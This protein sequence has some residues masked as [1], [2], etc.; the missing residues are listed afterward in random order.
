MSPGMTLYSVNAVIILGTDDGS[1][2]FSKYY[3]PPH[4]ATGTL[5]HRLEGYLGQG[6][7][8]DYVTMQGQVRTMGRTAT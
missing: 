4:T 6:T 1:R 5:S 8:A 7:A 3:A 2:I